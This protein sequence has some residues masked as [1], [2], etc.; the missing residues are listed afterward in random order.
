MKKP[1]YKTLLLG[2][3]SII[4]FCCKPQNEVKDDKKYK[5]FDVH[6]HSDWWGEPNK[7]AWNRKEFVAQKD[8][9]SFIDSTFWY[10]E[11]YNFVKVITDGNNALSFAK[12]E[13]NK[14]IPAIA[15]YGESIDSLRKWFLAGKYKVMAEFSPQ[16][17]S[18]AP[19]DTQLD[20]YYSLAEELKIPIG[21]HIGLG[22][23]GAAYIDSKNYRMSISK[24]IL[25][26]EVL[27]KHPKLRIYIMHAGWPY[28]DDIIALLYAHPQVFVDVAVINWF[29]PKS[30]FHSYL[31]RIVEAGFA[32]R[33]MYGSD[34]MIWPQSIKTSVENIKTADF[35]TEQQKEDIF[36]NNAA[37]FFQLEDK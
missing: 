30:E 1:F 29:V 27:I 25:L 3:F 7:V 10:L 13:P 5:I 9:K 6:L 15:G 32:D 17:S 35:L 34:Q 26:E 23:P 18:I 28:L 2:M 16:Y 22:P 11:E 24:A 33:I 20:K 8:E 19:N 21:I 36:Y 37:R 14:I 4:L 12:R 31:K